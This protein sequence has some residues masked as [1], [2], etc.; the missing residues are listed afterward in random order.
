MHEEVFFL[1]Y[2]IDK[3]IERCL[4]GLL[5]SKCRKIND[6]LSHTLLNWIFYN[7]TKRLTV[8]F[9]KDIRLSVVF[10]FLK[11]KSCPNGIQS[12][13]FLIKFPKISL[14]LKNSWAEVINLSYSLLVKR[15]DSWTIKAVS[16]SG[17]SVTTNW[18]IKEKAKYGRSCLHSAEML[19]IFYAYANN[20][21]F[22]MCR[23][24]LWSEIL[25]TVFMRN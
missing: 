14:A 9:F 25:K 4:Y 18:F 23:H 8:I 11:S 1:Y 7:K 10:Y 6:F 19:N 16:S 5:K 20:F 15:F 24:V 13:L 2:E 17:F 12:E 22:K 3:N 21:A